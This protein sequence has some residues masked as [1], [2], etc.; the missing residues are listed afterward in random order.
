[1]MPEYLSTFHKTDHSLDF[2][3]VVQTFIIENSK[4][5]LVNL[6]EADWSNS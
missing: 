1:M 3:E 6:A 4:H 2:S 5:I